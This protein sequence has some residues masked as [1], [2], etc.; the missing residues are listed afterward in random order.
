MSE[1]VFRSVVVYDGECSFCRRQ[2]ARIQR[3]DR[4]NQFEYVARQAVGLE[5]RF[6]RLAEGDFNTGMRL[7][8]PEGRIHVGADAV[9]EI[10]R[11]LPAW[12]RLAWVY[13]LPIAHRLVR[14][15]YKWIAAHRRSLGQ[16]CASGACAVSDERG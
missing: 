10:A 9:Y 14:L 12:R 4:A 2:I 1:G 7:I 13:R 8:D 16:S 15:V 5:Q 11:R 6:P 3:S